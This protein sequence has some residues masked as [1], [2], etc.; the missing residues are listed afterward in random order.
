MATLNKFI[1]IYRKVIN[2]DENINIDY[3]SSLTIDLGIDSLKRIQLGA[4][5]EDEF[6]I[7]LDEKFLSFKTVKEV[8]DCIDSRLV[9]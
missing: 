3:D 7:T 9:K 8:I 4:Y 2:Q 6:D 5:I 1:E